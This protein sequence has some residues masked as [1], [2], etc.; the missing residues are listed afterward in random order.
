MGSTIV[1]YFFSIEAERESGTIMTVEWR[2]RVGSLLQNLLLLKCL[3]FQQLI[4]DRFTSISLSD[5]FELGSTAT[6]FFCASCP[7]YCF[8]TFSLKRY[9]ME[10]FSWSLFVKYVILCSPLS[11]RVRVTARA[12]AWFLIRRVEVRLFVM[13]F[14]LQSCV[15]NDVQK[16]PF[17]HT[18]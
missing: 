1:C 9:S 8:F 11:K 18:F 17:I 7:A 10:P 6:R 3:Q 13:C 15:L 5:T 14:L 12:L 16:K 2:Q 4:V